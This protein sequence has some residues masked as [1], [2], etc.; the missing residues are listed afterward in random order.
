[1]KRIFIAIL[2]AVLFLFPACQSVSQPV[3]CTAVS[4]EEET[5][6]VQE[7]AEPVQT[8]KPTVQPVEPTQKPTP[9]P[10]ETP[11]PILTEQPTETTK[12]IETAKPKQIPS[13]QPMTQPTA[14]PTEKPTPIPT[15]KPTPQPT[16][17]PTVESTLTPTPEPEVEIIPVS[18]SYIN[19]AM[20]EINRLREA[21]GVAPATYSG[22]ISSSCQSHAVKMAESCSPFHASGIYMFEAVGRAS[23]HM[24]GGTMG[25]SAANHVVQLQSEEVTKIGIGAVYYGDY[26]FYV[27]RGE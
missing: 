7:A 19:A 15:A 25:G 6:L 17:E 12:P 22:S 18:S 5:V 2:I 1:M 9:E 23:R 10:I 11:E 13:L 16:P 20:A 27:V 21:K 24:S 8:E 14:K 26:V 4:F 3:E